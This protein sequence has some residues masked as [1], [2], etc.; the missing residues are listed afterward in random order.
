M[1]NPVKHENLEYAG[2][3]TPLEAFEDLKNNPNSFLIDVRTQAE[4]AF[5]GVSDLS[6]IG[7]ETILLQWKIYPQMQIN[8]D[9]VRLFNKA[10]EQLGV[11]EDSNLFF[12]CKTG[13]R[14][15]DAAEKMTKNGYKNCF[16]VA[17]GF[18]GDRTE[19]GQRGK[20]NGWKADALPWS[21][22]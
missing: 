7:K 1:L 18:E 11:K 4:W 22:P 16:N 10:A 6:E 8:P 3:V 2:D 13:G 14:S 9:F 15:L 12:I 5:V 19:N 17:N 20:V 21:Q